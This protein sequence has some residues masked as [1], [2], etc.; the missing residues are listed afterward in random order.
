M[1]TQDR[2]SVMHAVS[3]NVNLEKTV[4][5]LNLKVETS[6]TMNATKAPKKQMNIV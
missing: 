1:Y 2:D 5:F 4:G 3:T 6:N